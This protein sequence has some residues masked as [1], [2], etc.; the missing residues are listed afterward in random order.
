[1]RIVLDAMGT[2]Q[3]PEP[4]VSGA[5]VAAREYG[6]TIL[7][8]GDETKI[9]NE[10]KKH[11][12]AGLKLEIIHAPEEIS[13]DDKPSVVMKNKP[14][15]SMHV[16]MSLVRD[17]QADAFVTM[18]NTGAAHAIAMLSVLRRMPGVDRPALTAIYPIKGQ[19]RIFL[20][21]GA[22]TDC[23]P[24][25]LQQFAIM[26]SLYA[27]KVLGLPAPRV[28]ILSNG[29]EEGK[30]NK[31]TRE[32]FTMLHELDITFTGYIEPKEI[33]AGKADVIV[34]DGFIGNVFMK[35]FEAS[36]GFMGSTIREELTSGLI[37][38]LG[39]LLIRPAFRRVRQRIDPNEVGGAPLLG[40]NGLVII[41]HGSGNVVAVKSAINQ[42]RQAV[43][44]NCL[45][46][47]REGMKRFE[48]A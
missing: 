26:G 25:W 30:G 11:T 1:M 6:D 22:N 4:D 38:T 32:A 23:K 31:L 41:G 35:T 46:A 33:L 37:T 24:E 7:L 34:A 40:V 15:S 28:S 3:R 20:D 36:V 14:E 45:D 17:G 42:A 39:A 9:R 16:G 19:K 29:E 43:L 44:S 8:V 2:D 18:G 21:M 47:I 27:Q 5:V 12:T 48:K 10:L 13:M